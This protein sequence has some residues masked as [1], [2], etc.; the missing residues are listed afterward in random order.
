V[1]GPPL[2]QLGV[3]LRPNREVREEAEAGSLLP[4]SGGPTQVGTTP[5][6]AF[7]ATIGADGEAEIE[8]AV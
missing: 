3:M 7:R 8:A 4:P 5:S 1:G 6:V 2:L